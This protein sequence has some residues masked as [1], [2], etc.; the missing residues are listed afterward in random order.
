MNLVINIYFFPLFHRNKLFPES[1]VRNIMY[2]ILQGLAFIHKHGRLCF[3]YKPSEL[4]TDSVCVSFLINRKAITLLTWAERMIKR[5]AVYERFRWL[6]T[7]VFYSCLILHSGGFLSCFSVD[8][9]FLSLA[10]GHS[11]SLGVNEHFL[12]DLKVSWDWNKEET[13]LF[14][15]YTQI[16]EQNTHFL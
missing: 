10:A 2:Q 13:T 14:S 11:D 7:P 3:S 6:K 8:F 12:I 5:V 16:T 15:R 4:E 1:T 9:H